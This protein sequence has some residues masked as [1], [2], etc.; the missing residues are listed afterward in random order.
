MATMQA[1]HGQ[2]KT[3]Q[4]FQLHSRAYIPIDP[5]WRQRMFQIRGPLVK[6]DTDL[7]MGKTILDYRTG[8]KATGKLIIN[9]NNKCPQ[10]YFNNLLLR[11]ETQTCY[12]NI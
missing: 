2:D 9:P 5:T 11:K 10:M 3:G 12:V 4:D 1:F 7:V 6:A 8:R